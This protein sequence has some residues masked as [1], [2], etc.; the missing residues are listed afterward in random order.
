MEVEGL[1]AE[2]SAAEARAWLRDQVR[3][4]SLSEVDQFIYLRALF[5]KLPLKLLALACASALDSQSVDWADLPWN[6]R[7]RR[8]VARSQP[9]SVML[10]VAPFP[11]S[12][13]GLGRVIQVADSEK[14]LGSKVVFRLL[15]N[16]AEK[17]LIGGLVKGSSGH[18]EAEGV[19]LVNE[20]E[21]LAQVQGGLSVDDLGTDAERVVRALRFLLVYAVSQAYCDSL[22]L[23]GEPGTEEKGRMPPIEEAPEAPPLESGNSE[24]LIRWA[25][26]RAA[27][28][29]RDGPTG[30][31]VPR[32]GEVFLVIDPGCGLKGGFGVLENLLSVYGLHRVCFDQ[33]CLGA[34]GLYPS[35]LVT[36][37][38]FLFETL[39]EVRVR[40]DVKEALEVLR[41]FCPNGIGMSKVGWTGQLLRV[42]QGAWTQWTS[43]VS[44]SDEA[45]ERQALLKRLSEAESYARHVARDHS[46][47]R[48]GCPI[49]IMS[50]GRRRS[51]WR[52][53]H[54]VVHALSADIAGPF[55]AGQSYDEEASGRARHG[56][57]R[58]FLACSYTV[59]QSFDFPDKEGTKLSEGGEGDDELVPVVGRS[60]EEGLLE[61][62]DEL[63]SLPGDCSVRVVD[64]RVSA[65]RPE[66]PG[67]PPLED[68]RDEAEKG[69]GDGTVGA[70][71]RTL[72]IGVP[73]KSKAG[74]GVTLAVQGLVNKLEAHGFPVHRYHS[75]RAKELR[76]T[77]LLTWM[78]QQGIH[79]TST[80]GEAPSGNRA[81]LAVQNLKA[82]VRKLLHASGLDKMFWPLALLHASARNWSDFSISLGVPCSH[83]IPFGTK[84]HARCRS[85]TGYDANWRS[86]S[87]QGVFVG[88]APNVS[89]GYLVLV[90]EEGS[91]GE[92]K[93]LLTS[94][95]YP[96][97]GEPSG[98]PRRPRYR[99]TS[100]RSPDFALRAVAATLFEKMPGAGNWFAPG[101]ESLGDFEIKVLVKDDSGE[102]DWVLEGDLDGPVGS[103]TSAYHSTVDSGELLWE[104]ESCSILGVKGVRSSDRNNDSWVFSGDP[105]RSYQRPEGRCYNGKDWEGDRALG[106]DAFG[107]ICGILIVYVDD[108]AFLGPSGLCQEFIRVVQNHWKTSAPQWLGVEPVTF[109]GIELTLQDF[110]FRM[111]QKAYIIELLQ[112]YNVGTYASSPI[113]KWVEPEIEENPSPEAIKEAQAMTGA[114]L[115]ISTRTRPDL[116]YVV[117][118]CGQQ[119]TKAPGLSIS[120]AKQ[121]LA[122]LQ[123]TQ[124]LGIEVLF[125]VGN[126]FS[127][128][129][130]LAL[131]RTEKVIELYTDA[132]HSP[133]GERSMQSV[134]IVWRGVPVAWEAT[135]QP[136]TTLSSA[137]AELVCMVHGIQL[138]EAVQ[139]LIDELI[140]ADSMISLLGDNEA[141]VRAF[142]TASAGWRNRH[143]R[144]RAVAGRERIDAGLLKVTHLPGEYQVELMTAEALAGLALLAVI[145]GVKG[146][147]TQDEP[148]LSPSERE[149][150]GEE[151][152]DGLG[153]DG[154]PNSR[155][156]PERDTGVFGL[157]DDDFT[158]E[159]WQEATR[160]LQLE[161]SRFGGIP[162]WAQEGRGIQERPLNHSRGSTMRSFS[163]MKGKV[164]EH[165]EAGIPFDPEEYPEDIQD[166]FHWLNLWKMEPAGTYEE[167]ALSNAVE[168]M[169]RRP[170]LRGC[171][172]EKLPRELWSWG[173]R[174]ALRRSRPSTL[175]I[176]TKGLLEPDYDMAFGT[177]NRASVGPRV[178]RV[179][180]VREDL[181]G[182]AGD[183]QG[184]P[185]QE[186]K[187]E[188]LG[189]RRS[190]GAAAEALIE[191]EGVQRPA[192]APEDG[193]PE[194]TPADEDRLGR[195]ER[196]LVSMME[197]NKA[198]KR[199]LEQTES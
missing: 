161:E 42:V 154:N 195:M 6:R 69:S 50:Q 146:Q 143:L 111:T 106:E 56:G 86:R 15:M 32:P 98:A 14:G 125:V 134:F 25:I 1:G 11:N 7:F 12:W 33:G 63:L 103:E 92:M 28:Q 24:D 102:E 109:C 171:N 136:F 43:E 149:L 156:Q 39:H 74:K 130:L 97:R 94:T 68:T 164:K 193:G 87:T 123:G 19:E 119:A 37:S 174:V 163:L 53:S 61:D 40:G 182:I 129:G 183:F 196:L 173:K 27:V 67:P 105:S 23:K 192:E 167:T 165:P 65:K 84:V 2:L 78:K 54:P 184:A 169:I 79:V 17:G 168:G 75:D 8:S 76:T 47:F 115:W 91:E 113:G 60:E 124:D 5:P 20:F 83:L 57:Y 177:E 95:I 89:G 175:D 73:L 21:R 9:G 3:V 72:F 138:S 117:S 58:F 126:L 93:V 110:G 18:R 22:S 71:M 66:L 29:L 44:R 36:S 144:M 64:R 51:H 100:K 104:E 199:K 170:E 31:G 99:L 198:L 49:C 152:G 81:E 153:E 181:P 118:R 80:P 194:L 158:E 172:P 121:A 4:K 142:E 90:P 46:P 96:L 160:K 70:K 178:A 122:Y 159:E 35:G 132:S 176:A 34:P 62:L 141:S 189:S 38:W 128:H 101:G 52:T 114:L 148:T 166:E 197:E 26:K 59:P 185:S 137:E 190:T 187:Q 147:P 13:K 85:K 179:E 120:L 186:V 10:A 77:A 145:P 155:S 116:S 45:V 180:T 133:G 135:R 157:S 127:D 82:F 108:L 88:P 41:R 131:P 150:L 107:D 48:K 16:W 162:D 112:R 30:T 188:A 55:R 140:E 191:D 139:P 151:S